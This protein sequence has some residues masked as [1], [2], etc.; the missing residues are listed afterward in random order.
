MKTI[1]LFFLVAKLGKSQGIHI[2]IYNNMQQHQLGTILK[3]FENASEL[4]QLFCFSFI[5]AR[6]HGLLCRALYEL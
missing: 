5:T 2:S 1:H 4:C 3:H 6:Q